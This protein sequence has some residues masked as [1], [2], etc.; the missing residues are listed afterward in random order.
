MKEC[1][2]IVMGFGA[3]GQGVARAISLKKDMIKER[4]NVEL[5]IVAAA[6]SSSSAI[7]ADGLDEE[8][9]V[10]IKNEFGKLSNYPEYGSTISGLD[11][12]DAVEY[13]CLMEATPTNITDA[14]PALS[15]TLKAFKAGKDVVT[16]NKGHL[17]LNS[18]KL[19][20]KLRKTMLNLNMKPVLVE[21]CRL[22]IS[23]KKHFHPVES[24]Q[25]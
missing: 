19:Y 24:N 3:V 15:L 21:Q 25:L 12:L 11:V 10:N 1:K 14:E 17:A 23:Q 4:F 5:K 7:C 22:L 8:L 16:S 13:D 20:P 18:E 2:V 9:L 6:D